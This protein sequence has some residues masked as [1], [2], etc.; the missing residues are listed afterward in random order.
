MR[1][2]L[3]LNFVFLLYSKKK[4]NTSEYTLPLTQVSQKLFSST[5]SNISGRDF[6]FV[7]LPHFHIVELDKRWV[8]SYAVCGH[9]ITLWL[10]LTY[11]QT[12]AAEISPLLQSKCD[13]I[14]GE[15]QSTCW[16]AYLWS[17]SPLVG[18]RPNRRWQ[19]RLYPGD[20][21]CGCTR[22]TTLVTHGGRCYQWTLHLYSQKK[23]NVFN[24]IF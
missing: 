22:C 9:V 8:H 10:L 24:F 13:L 5:F 6:G 1:H 11:R 20:D 4:K 16:L 19:L 12:L 2:F 23:R 21:S 3:F 7:D 17:T 14:Y 18:W 15:V